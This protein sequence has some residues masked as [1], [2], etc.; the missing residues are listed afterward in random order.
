MIKRIISTISRDLHVAVRDN[1]ML[2]IL[3]APLLLAGIMRLF[4]P[5]VEGMTMTFAV[6]QAV[7]S[8]YG[9]ELS[10]YGSIEVFETREALLD[11]IN[12][13]DDVPGFAAEDGGFTVI[14][15]GNEMESVRQLSEV[16]L[17]QAISETAQS[18]FSIEDRGVEETQLAQLSAIILVILSLFMGGTI[19]GFI[20][21][22]EKETLA[23]R[24]LAVTPLRLIDF[25]AA[26]G[27]LA[28]AIS[29]FLATGS[30]FILVG[31]ELNYLLLILSVL[32]SAILATALGFLT[33]AVADSQVSAI[34]VM[35]VT[36]IL[37]LAVPFASF[38]IPENLHIL[39]YP[40]P[41]FWMF[42]MF[43]LIFLGPDTGPELITSA[44]LTIVLSAATITAMI[45]L[46][47]KRLKIR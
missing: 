42:R 10:S 4:I 29:L 2:Y 38:F 44:A 45:P 3:V 6:E 41:N 12:D 26:R 5:Q 43:K 32:L 15:E 18:Q 19:A 46:F 36:V 23:I 37:F 11:R 30:A 25:I 17:M 21:V 24:A 40:F 47:R 22:E 27:A 33:G 39:L 34:A 35:K 14:L 7:Y 1:L 20:I 8:E 28:L 9:E 13:P 16:V 31:T